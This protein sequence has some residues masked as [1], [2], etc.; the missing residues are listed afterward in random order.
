MFQEFTV[1]V[2]Y[3]QSE[4]EL[5]K[6]GNYAKVDFDLDATVSHVLE[7]HEVILSPLR[8]EEGGTVNYEELVR[9]MKPDFYPV[10]L[11][12]L[13]VFGA[14]KIACPG[15][16]IALETCYGKKMDWWTKWVCIADNGKNR[17]LRRGDE[18]GDLEIPL[19]V[20]SVYFLGRRL[21]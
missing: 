8:F 6:Q 16:L 9:R 5:A 13:L 12:E 21:K 15:A 7:R 2:D 17:Y 11:R 19:D 10:G 14:M 18:L 4:V 3:T 20:E 1:L